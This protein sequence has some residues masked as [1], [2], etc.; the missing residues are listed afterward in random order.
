MEAENIEMTTTTQNYGEDE[1]NHTRKRDN[2]PSENQHLLYFPPP[3]SHQ[4]DPYASLKIVKYRECLKNHAASMGCHVVDGC[5]EFM[6]TG[7]EDTL[8]SLRCDACGCHRNFHRKEIYVQG[9]NNN[10]QE[11]KQHI[12]SDYY[13]SYYYSNKSEDYYQRR[14]GSFASPL[15]VPPPRPPP[16]SLHQQQQSRLIPRGKRFRTKFTEEQKKRMMEYAEKIGW[17]MQKNDEQE[18]GLFCSQVGV[19]RQVFKIWM[20]NNKQRIKLQ[21]QV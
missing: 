16:P 2:T 15:V 21:Q 9:N 3:S 5:G 14:H 19:K 6:P 13:C 10:K 20:H 8:A 4:S 17:K 18:V 11:Q 1:D 7:E 12:I